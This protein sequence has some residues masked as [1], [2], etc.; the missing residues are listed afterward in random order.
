[1]NVGRFRDRAT[2]QR[3]TVTNVRG[4]QQRAW[5]TTIIARAPV[6]VETAAGDRLER[7][8]GIGVGAERIEGVQ[9]HLV[10]VRA[11]MDVR[12][13]D[14]WIWHSHR[15]DIPLEVTAVRDAGALREFVICACEERER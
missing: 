7:V 14:R 11:P 15:G 9:Q 5:D 3:A 2:L 10:T 8:F 4:V 6:E 1:M 13:T 12:L